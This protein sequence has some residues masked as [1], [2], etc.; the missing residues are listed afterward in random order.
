MDENPCVGLVRVEVPER[1]FRWLKSGEDIATLLAACS[2]SI[3]P[4]VALLVGTGMRLDEALHLRW[5][6]VDLD[7]RLIQVQHGRQGTTKSGK[8]RPVPIFDSVLPM[9]RELALRRAGATLVFPSR[10][11][12]RF[13]EAYVERPRSKPGVFKPFKA[14][15]ATA[16]LD[17]A[18]RLHDL[19]HTFASLYLLD[20]G[21][22]FRL[23]K[24]LGHS[25]VATTEKVYAH[26][27]PD[28]W[29]QD[30]GRVAFRIPGGEAK[31]LRLTAL[32]AR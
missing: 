11:R 29:S 6:D 8:A 31:V 10:E 25:S 22:I 17:T 32:D 7:R 27:K 18:L 4:I 14:A 9:L 5:G 1:S 20:G 23:S 3:R 16:K 21:D 26:M 28:A 19:R 30:Y 2:A 24:I 13:G 15:L 12:P